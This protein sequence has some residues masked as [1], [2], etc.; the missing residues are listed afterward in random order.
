MSRKKIMAELFDL[1]VG[2]H[3]EPIS[4]KQITPYQNVGGDLDQLPHDIF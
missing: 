2:R 4:E 1:T 3:P